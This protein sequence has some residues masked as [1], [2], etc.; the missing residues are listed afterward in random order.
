MHFAHF[1][2]ESANIGN[3]LGTPCILESKKILT[4]PSQSKLYDSKNC[5]KIRHILVLVD[6]AYQSQDSPS[7]IN[8]LSYYRCVVCVWRGEGEAT[9]Q[10]PSSVIIIYMSNLQELSRPHC[11]PG[12]DREMR[13]RPMGISQENRRI[14]QRIRSNQLNISIY[15]ILFVFVP[16]HEM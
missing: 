7:S 16:M 13:G 11:L 2:S 1:P 5:L 4:Q 12:P 8:C 15:R 10:S 6:L 3:F 9:C 14:V